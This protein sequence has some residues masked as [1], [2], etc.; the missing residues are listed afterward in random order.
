MY[1]FILESIGT[2]ELLL[3][4]LIALMF[5]GPRRLPEIA[6][7]FGKIMNEFRRTSSEFKQ[8]WEREVTTEINQ[9]KEE[10]SFPANTETTGNSIR[11]KTGT[12][13][14]APEI[15]EVSKEDFDESLAKK[16]P[17]EAETTEA[18]D[19]LAVKQNW[20]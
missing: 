6:R 9:I 1:L 10:V 13:A 20:L 8:T 12:K 15:K 7:K 19:D 5:L 3:I 11:K 17:P 2:S 4:G 16:N 18:E 14:A